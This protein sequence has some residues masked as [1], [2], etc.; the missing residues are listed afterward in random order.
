MEGRDRARL[1]IRGGRGTRGGPN[2]YCTIYITLAD[3]FTPRWLLSVR[4][5]RTRTAATD[6]L[7]AYIL[8]HTPPVPSRSGWSTRPSPPNQCVLRTRIPVPENVFRKKTGKHYVNEKV[9]PARPPPPMTK[10]GWWGGQVKGK[11]ELGSVKFSQS[12]YAFIILYN[13][14]K[15]LFFLKGFCT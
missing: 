15:G 13:A 2:V 5:P 6:G 3:H 1:D 12:I 11:I 8:A 9:S 10:G 14:V 7:D 4:C